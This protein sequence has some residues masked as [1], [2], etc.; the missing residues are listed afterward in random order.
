MAVGAA[1]KRETKYIYMLFRGVQCANEI[2]M[3]H[4]KT[5]ELPL[6]NPEHVHRARKYKSSDYGDESPNN[7]KAMYKCKTRNSHARNNATS[8]KYRRHTHK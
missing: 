2:L 1:V 4:N 7:K 3:Q 6:I 5:Q 8:R